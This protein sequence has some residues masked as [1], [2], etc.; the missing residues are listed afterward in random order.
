MSFTERSLESIR[1]EIAQF[2]IEREWDQFH[3]PRN[4][5][6]ALM[7]EIGEVA[8]IVRWQGDKDPSIPTDKRTA[9]EEE[10]ADVFTLL[11]RL[12]DRSGVD[13]TTAFE[14][15]LAQAREKYPVDKFRGSSR[16]YDE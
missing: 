16:K 9:W 4:L 10:L 11:I 3:S 2:A 13:L 5:L 7:G 12:A 8:E 15:K 14:K 1:Q 6:F